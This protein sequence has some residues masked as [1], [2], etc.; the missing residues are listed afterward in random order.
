MAL[1]EKRRH[2]KLAKK[3]AKRKAKRAGQR[4]LSLKR[5]GPSPAQAAHFP[6]QDCLVRE[7]LFEIGIGHVMLTRSLP[8]GQVAIAAFLLDVYCLGVKNAFYRV[9]SAQDYAFTRHQIEASTGHLETVHPSCLRKLVEG[10]LDYARNLG[11]APHSDYANAAKL[12]GDIEGAA[13]PVRYTYGKDGK[14]LYLSDPDE[15][16]ARLRRVI[17]TLTRRLGPEGFH[18]MTAFGDTE[19]YDSVSQDPESQLL[20]LNYTISHEPVTD[21]AYERLPDSVRDQLETIHNMLLREPKEAMALLQPLIEK[22][23]E[24]PQLYNYLHVIYQKLRDRDNAQRVLQETLERFP[25][26]LFGRIAYAIDCLQ[27]GKPEKVPEILDNKYE[28][29]LL[30]PKRERFHISEVLGFY[31][32][33]AWYFHTQGEHARAET[34]YKLLQQLD[35]EHPNTRFIKQLLYP[36]W[37]R[38]WLRTL[39]PKPPKSI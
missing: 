33:L 28:L 8:D 24:V 15:S 29:K 35:P 22:Y 2:K 6:I 13:C 7:E 34:Y 9:V 32:L 16:P 4:P 37:L 30:Y 19:E 27:R 38:R 36:S 5:G 21:P 18:Y 11:F 39:L 26:Y 25:D 31:S 20:K 1:D 12:F 14:P 17:D 3:A 10:A 23:P